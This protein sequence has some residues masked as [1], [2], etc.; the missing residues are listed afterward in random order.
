MTGCSLACLNILRAVLSAFDIRSGEDCF[1]AFN[2]KVIDRLA[3]ELWLGF[4]TSSVV[5]G[6]VMSLFEACS[7]LETIYGGK[8]LQVT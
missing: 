8:L 5:E 6:L 2:S 3:E 4:C 1:A 7:D